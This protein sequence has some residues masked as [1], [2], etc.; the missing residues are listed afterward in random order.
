MSAPVD[1]I[2]G[3][4]LCLDCV[5]QA[6]E[7]GERNP[8][9]SGMRQSLCLEVGDCED[10]TLVRVALRL[11]V[12]DIVEDNTHHLQIS[13]IPQRLKHCKKHTLRAASKSFAN[14][15]HSANAGALTYTSSAEFL[16]KTLALAA[17]Q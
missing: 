2:E 6:R 5:D 12:Q 3:G 11:V 16:W 9:V 17:A 1:E 14:F 4:S 10:V 7:V 13:C 15:S 8:L